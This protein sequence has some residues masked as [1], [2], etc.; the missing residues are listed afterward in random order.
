MTEGSERAAF[1]AL[2]PGGWRDYWSLLHPP[3]TLW[4]L[5]YVVIG[6][7]LAAEVRVGWLLETL[8]AFFLAMGLAAHALDE[9]NG[10]PLRTRIPDGVLWAIAVVGLGGAVALG[11][12]GS[13]EVSPWLWAFIAAGLFLVVA[14]NLELFGGA[15]HSDLW[16]ALAWGAFPVLVAAFAQTAEVRPEAILAAVACAAISAAQRVLST[17]VRR[18]RRSIASVEGT[19]VTS[20]GDREAIDASTLRAAPEGALRWLSVAMPLLAAAMLLSRLD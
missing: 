16:F 2:S 3:Y 9:L 19:V 15:V 17:P 6:A 7:S 4:H 1:Y 8:L 18:L 10:R 12:H 13:L 11:I 14:Y 20:D 5:S